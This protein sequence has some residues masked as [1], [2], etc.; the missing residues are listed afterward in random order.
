MAEVTPFTRI[1]SHSRSIDMS[2]NDSRNKNEGHDGFIWSQYLPFAAGVALALALAVARF[3]PA[4][5]GV[6]EW[7]K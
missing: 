2:T 7:Q 6:I 5:A 3:V 4:L 1:A